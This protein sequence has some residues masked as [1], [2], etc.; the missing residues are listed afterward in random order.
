[1]HLL[2]VCIYLFF[3]M[4]KR[5]DNDL[6]FFC[7]FSVLFSN[8]CHFC[9][10]ISCRTA[11][12]QVGHGHWIGSDWNS[13]RAGPRDVEKTW[14]TTRYA[15]FGTSFTSFSV[16]LDMNNTLWIRVECDAK[17]NVSNMS[18][19]SKTIGSIDSVY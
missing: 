4:K 15:F 2:T 9:C 14:P 11:G 3:L 7:F 10:I 6:W 13:S 1:M 16:S 12:A 8:K 17:N 19:N 5:I 18:I